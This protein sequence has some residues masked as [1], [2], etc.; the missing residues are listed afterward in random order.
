MTDEVAGLV[1]RNND[2]QTL[3]LSLAE[4]RGPADLGF[5]QRLMQTLER[6]GRLN[7][8]VEFLPDDAALS[9]RALRGE[10]LT[11][12][13]LAVLLAYAKLDLHDQILDSRVPDD[14]YFARELD[15]Y[16]PAEMRARFPEAIAG[17]R[18]RR[19]IIATQLANA[20]INRGGPTIVSRL[21][22]P[23]GTDAPT[24][25]AAAAP[26][27]ARHRPP[28]HRGGLRGDPRLLRPDRAQCRDRRA[29]RQGLG[30]LPAS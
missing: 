29:R 5:A 8:A 18:L 16:F 19:D 7:R 22:H 27:P 30:S 10:A 14:P 9:E 21:A 28:H 15:R 1:L 17:H 11:R 23:T 26:R 24:L 3:A 13:E 20:I 12:P 25:H 2:L 6:E 4:R